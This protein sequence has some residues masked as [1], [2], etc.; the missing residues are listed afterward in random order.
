M[1]G[2]FDGMDDPEGIGEGSMDGKFDG[3]DDPEG[4]AVDDGSDD[5]EGTLDGIDDVEGSADG[6]M[7]GLLDGNDELEGRAD[8]KIDGK[9]DGRDDPDGVLVGLDV[10]TT[11]P[12]PHAQQPSLAVT[13]VHLS[14]SWPYFSQCPRMLY[15]S[16]SL[17]SL[18]WQYS[19][20]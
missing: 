20:K 2:K 3:K 17:T 8:G 5:P 14:L 12:P 10:K 19:F 16:Q 7:D 11:L 9:V 4:R 13:C 18:S 1:D 15:H 6:S